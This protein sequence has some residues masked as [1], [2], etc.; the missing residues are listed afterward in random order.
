MS[1]FAYKHYKLSKHICIMVKTLRLLT[2]ML[3]V[4]LCT[5][6]GAQTVV[7]FA[8]GLPDDWTK[9][10]TVA[11]LAYSEKNCLQLQSN[12][13]ITSPAM[14]GAYTKLNISLTR[15]KKGQNFTVAYKLG[16]AAA[17]NIKTFKSSDVAKAAWD[18]YT[19]E[20]PKEAQVADCQFVFTVTTASYYI[21]QIEF[22]GADAPKK[23]QT[24]TTFGEGIDENKFTYVGD[25]TPE[26][27]TASVTPAEALANGTLTYESSNPNIVTVDATTGALTFGKEYGTAKITATFAPAEGALF[28]T[29]T[30]SY[31]VRHRHAADPKTIVFDSSEDEAFASINK[32]NQYS[33]GDVEFIDLNNDSY[34]FTVHNA[35]VN[36]YNG[37]LQLKKK[38]STDE[39]KQ[40]KITSPV[41]EKFDYGYRVTV[42]YELGHGIELGCLNYPEEN[43]DDVYSVDDENGTVYMDIPYYDGIFTIAGGDEVSYVKSIE[44][45]PLAKPKDP[46]TLA[47]PQAEYVV[48][49]D[50]QEKFEG[51]KAT[52]TNELGSTLDL[53]ITYSIDNEDFALIDSNDGTVA[54]GN[55]LGSAVI[56]ARFAGN[57]DYSPAEA[58]Y[59]LR[60]VKKLDAGIAYEQ[61][62]KEAELYDETEKNTSLVNPN[63]FALTYA[64]SNEDVATVDEEGNVTL[65]A[66]GTT[67]IKASFAGDATHKAAEA[68]YTLNVKDSRQEAGLAFAEE[69]LEVNIMKANEITGMELQNPNNLDVV[70]SSSNPEV[71][72]VSATSQTITLLGEGETT[73][74]AAFAGD[75]NFFAGSA[76]YTLKVINE[77][78][79]AIGGITADSLNQTDRVYNLQG[80]RV[81]VKHLSKGVYV[82]NGKKVVVK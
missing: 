62:E 7:S 66:V 81:D 18:T 1:N 32:G 63:N 20:L 64:S 26:G 34:T 51:V 3:L 27:K 31:Y 4:T 68:S 76:S 73:I 55:T 42:K 11:N 78:I 8:D 10:G 75:R 22:V 14:S 49:D 77:P 6:V 25:E 59:T 50:E 21:S 54:I 48:Y 40:G 30:A 71:A 17:V 56:T 19:V 57:A 69:S 44:L 24:T 12:A 72:I 80:A 53:P 58:T 61:T 46:T 33:D 9:T 16:T 65:K 74:T 23:T 67:V 39:E 5:A 35:M 36:Q 38:S 60:L 13:S 43:F 70:Y 37:M 15:S 2:L 45:T 41:F 79:T 47:F 52:L 29:S 82:V 28:T